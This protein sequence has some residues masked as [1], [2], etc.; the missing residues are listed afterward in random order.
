MFFFCSID[1]VP[2]IITK[3]DTRIRKLPCATAEGGSRLQARFAE[4]RSQ[5]CDGL[6]DRASTSYIY[7]AVSAL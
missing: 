4:R 7:E 1:N 6:V 5:K 2:K 3:G